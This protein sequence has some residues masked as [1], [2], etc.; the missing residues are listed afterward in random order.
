[1]DFSEFNV[2]IFRQ[3]KLVWPGSSILANMHVS[4]IY[5]D[6]LSS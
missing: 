6:S 3:I 2:A 4:G 1:M 5:A